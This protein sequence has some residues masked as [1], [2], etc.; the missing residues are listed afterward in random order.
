MT[1]YGR[2]Y[3][4]VR[5]ENSLKVAAAASA[6]ATTTSSTAATDTEQTECDDGN[7]A[8]ADQVN[9]IKSEQPIDNCTSIEWCTDDFLHIAAV[10]NANEI[11]LAR[12]CNRFLL[13]DT[14]SF[15]TAIWHEHYLDS[16]DERVM[17][18]FDE[19]RN[20]SDFQKRHYLLMDSVG[21]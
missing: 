17:Q 13:C 19:M 4:E 10:Q 18:I 21:T 9:V 16:V 8:T 20:Q 1:E 3:T 11:A 7:D 12:E 6:S 14:D 2:E 5:I 15:A